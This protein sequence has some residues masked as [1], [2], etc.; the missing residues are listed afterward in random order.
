MGGHVEAV[1][2]IVERLKHVPG[3]MLPILHAIQDEIG[4][5]PEDSVAIV[6][7]GLNVSRAEVH[8]VLT[9]YHHFRRDAP[10]RH[11]LQVCR[12]ESCQAAG[13]LEVQAKAMLGCD[14][15]E[16][17]KD[18]MFSLEPVYCLG[19]CASSPAVMIDDEVHAGLT[20]EKLETLI[21]EFGG[22]S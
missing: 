4:Y 6:A 18:G 2:R 17:S 3:A 16:N 15:H 8:G 21:R 7:E 5:V 20:P 1:S 11:V 9:F 19:L 12:A 14:F 13:S 10:A 22:K